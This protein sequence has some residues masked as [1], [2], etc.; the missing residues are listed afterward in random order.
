LNPEWTEAVEKFG[1]KDVTRCISYVSY[2]Q[3]PEIYNSVELLLFPS[4]YEGFGRPPLEA[5]AC[6]IPTV[7]SNA[8]SL[9]EVVGDASMLYA[10]D[11]VDGLAKAMLAILTNNRLRRMLIEAGL[12]RAW[13]FTFKKMAQ[14]TIEVYERVAHNLRTL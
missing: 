12:A 5:M 9:P 10:P 13:Q 3:M 6:G 8:A 11:D 7:V 1:L 2:N 4:L 14:Q